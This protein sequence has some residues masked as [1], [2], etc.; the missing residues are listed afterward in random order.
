MPRVERN[1]RLFGAM[2]GV[3]GEVGS[4][5][6][7]KGIPEDMSVITRLDWER[8]GVDAHTPSWFNE[9]NIDFLQSWLN[10]E[11][12]TAAEWGDTVPWGPYHLEF[13]IL[14]N[15]YLF[16]NN[17]TDFKHYHDVEYVPSNVAAVRLVF[18]FD[19]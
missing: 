9:E 8:W 15:T 4:T 17:L 3:R 12:Q 5:V 14:S 6:E 18:W 2:S 7:P 11:R 19:N 1:Y 16:G 13:G 10:N